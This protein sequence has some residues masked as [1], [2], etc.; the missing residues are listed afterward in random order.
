MKRAIKRL[1]IAGYCRGFISEGSVTFWFK[2]LH[3]EAI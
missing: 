2:H 3:L 1:L